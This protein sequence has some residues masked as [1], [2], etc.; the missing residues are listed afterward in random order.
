[1]RVKRNEQQ[2]YYMPVWVMGL[3]ATVALANVAVIALFVL[4]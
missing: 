2:Y 4:W 1:M 3:S